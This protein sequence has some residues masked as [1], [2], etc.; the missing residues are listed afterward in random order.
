MIDPNK[1]RQWGAV[2]DR[3]TSLHPYHFD[4]PRFK[5][6]LV[7]VSAS[8][9]G[10]WMLDVNN[11]RLRHDAHIPLLFFTK[12]EAEDFARQCA[13]KNAYWTYLPR[14]FCKRKETHDRT[15]NA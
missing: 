2:M 12:P 15:T 7:E 8:H 13:K 1:R 4:D 14:K 9:L 5:N 10:L 6:A 3:P 11:V